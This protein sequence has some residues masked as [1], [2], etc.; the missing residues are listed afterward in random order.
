MAAHCGPRPILKL[1]QR[2]SVSVFSRSQRVLQQLQPRLQ[3]RRYSHAGHAHKQETPEPLKHLPRK[4]TKSGERQLRHAE[5]VEAR[6][7]RSPSAFRQPPQPILSPTVQETAPTEPYFVRRTPTRNLPVYQLAK[8]GGNLKQTRLRKIEG[9]GAQLLRQLEL[10]L[11]PKPEWIRI[12]P[13]N[14]HINMKVS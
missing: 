10:Q 4:T 3:P 11:D 5:K 14:G 6:T 8:R 12:N 7:S 9:E 1:P 13:I 2:A